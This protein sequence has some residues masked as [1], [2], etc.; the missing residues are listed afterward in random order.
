MKSRLNHPHQPALLNLA[1]FVG[2]S[3]LVTLAI[4][5]LALAGMIESAFVWLGLV[6]LAVFGLMFFVIWILGIIQMR[7]V[8]AFLE[9]ERVLARWTYTAQEWQRL[10]E[11]HWQEEKDDWKV[12]LGCLTFL[13][14]LAGLLTGVMLG[15]ED[16]VLA[17]IPNALMGLLL[18]GLVGGV[19][20]ILVAGSNRWSAWQSY[21]H[22]EL[23][24]VALGENEIY[25]S[26]DY[27]RGDGRVSTIHRA[28]LLPGETPILRLNLVFPPRIRMPD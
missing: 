23:G 18:G 26:D 22:S 25:A 1:G 27:F 5:G 12:Q 17:V 28:S 13:L 19:F 15:W 14:A 2:L 10:K 21:R 11:S 16:G 20:G 7:R 8:R 9:S 24:Q 3:L 4:W 6:F